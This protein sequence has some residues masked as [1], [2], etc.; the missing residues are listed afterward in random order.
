M[1]GLFV[2][3][4]STSWF[5]APGCYEIALVELVTD[6]IL[7]VFAIVDPLYAETICYALV[8]LGGDFLSLPALFIPM[9][10]GETDFILL[11]T[12]FV[13]LI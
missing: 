5:E 1:S 9:R 13:L 10:D 3:V 2:G 8:G 4:S 6:P 7:L 11:T 12:T